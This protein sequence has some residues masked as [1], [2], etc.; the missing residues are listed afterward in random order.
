MEVEC[1]SQIQPFAEHSAPKSTVFLD[2]QWI[3]EWISGSTDSTIS[4][5][6]LSSTQSRSGSDRNSRWP[7][8][9]SSLPNSI[10]P[11]KNL[12]DDTRIWV[13]PPWISVGSW[14]GLSGGKRKLWNCGVSWTWYS[15]R[16]SLYIQ[17]YRGFRSRMFCEWLYLACTFDFHSIL[18]KICLYLT[19][20]KWYDIF[21]FR[22]R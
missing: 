14:P 13:W 8:S 19:Y 11:F 15:L 22:S 17:K 3:S 12:T 5:L 10:Y 21:L 9:N 16:N 2:I 20:K 18:T 7:N 6:P 1:A 4:Q